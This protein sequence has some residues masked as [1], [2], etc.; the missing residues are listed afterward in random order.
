[1]KKILFS[2]MAC[3][4]CLGLVGG[5]FAY[6][7]D[8]VNSNTNV[9]TAGT[10]SIQIRNDTGA[11]QNDAVTASFSASG[12]APGQSFETNF[13]QVKNTGSIDI[14][15]VYARFGGLT[16]PINF[17]DK[18]TLAY[19]ATS[20]NGASWIYQTF[21]DNPV[22]ANS[23]DNGVNPNDGSVAGPT[24]SAN[25]IAYINFW[26]GRG[27]DLPHTDYITL[28]DLVRARNLGSGDSITSLLLLDYRSNP[29]DTWPTSSTLAVKFGFLFDPTADNT[30]QGASLT[31]SVNFIASQ[32]LDYPDT[33]LSDYVNPGDLVP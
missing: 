2:L 22:F 14:P 25:A 9:M 1:M 4:L 18:L 10:L 29:S 11:W 24:G 23:N 19:Y 31:F 15:R 21:I 12:L 28:D 6:F 7:T 32:T 3:V 17:G 13:V 16:D 20:I 33:S 5:A 26:N 27:P 30:Y 8:V